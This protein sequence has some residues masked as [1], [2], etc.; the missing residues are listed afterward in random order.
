V[1]AIHA[2]PL[3][4]TARLAN[5]QSRIITVIVV[6]PTASF[7]DGLKQSVISTA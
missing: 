3:I 4:A 6:R 7:E 2:R 5:R 1:T